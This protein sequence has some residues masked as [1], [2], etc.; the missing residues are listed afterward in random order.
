L[1]KSDGFTP[2]GGADYKG[3]EIFGPICSYVGNSARYDQSYY[4][5][6]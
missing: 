6:L 1:R 5:S 4:W 3:V 2:N